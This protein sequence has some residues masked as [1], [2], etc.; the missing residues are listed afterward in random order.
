MPDF[1]DGETRRQ[2]EWDYVWDLFPPLSEI[3]ST[4]RSE[5]CNS[6]RSKV[7]LFMPGDFERWMKDRQDIELMMGI[8]QNPDWSERLLQAIRPMKSFSSYFEKVS[9]GVV[10]QPVDLFKWKQWMLAGH[11]LA[12]VLAEIRSSLHQDQTWF[13]WWPE[14][15]W[16]EAVQILNPQDTLIHT[17]SLDDQYDPVL[18]EIRTEKRQLQTQIDLIRHQQL[19]MLRSRYGSLPN[20]EHEYIW[21]QDDQENVQLAQM[22]SELERVG[23]TSW[24]VLFRVRD[25]DTTSSLKLKIE[26]LETLETD[27]ERLLLERLS[28]ELSAF[29]TVFHEFEKACAALDWL[30]V[31]VRKAHQSNWTFPIWSDHWEV[32][33][34]VHPLLADTLQKKGQAAVLISFYLRE[35]VSVITGPNMGGKTVSLRTAGLLQA[36]AQQGMPVPAKLFYF[37]PVNLV[38]FVGGDMQ[39]IEDGISTFGGE[40]LRLQE[41]L[42]LSGKLLLLLDEVG[43]G[44]NPL[45]GE[46][47]AVGVA[48][49]LSEAPCFALFATHYPSVAQVT[50]ITRWKISGLSD[51]RVIPADNKQLELESLM[52]AEQMGLPKQIIGFAKEWIQNYRK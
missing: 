13:T 20:R 21:S 44:T 27:R 41:V 14:V 22:D 38:R 29:V 33:E 25:R 50:G 35:G 43:R 47:L 30:I 51:H 16:E 23:E 40:M 2:I 7:S 45:E 11:Q 26:V 48:R 34:A 49:F 24:E 4:Y 6:Y 10:L 42:P 28:R 5:I 8:L 1:I 39:S 12:E 18:Q 17:F 46:A 15:K 9:A 19:Q 3:G 52:I 36:L 32:R 37:V 31:R